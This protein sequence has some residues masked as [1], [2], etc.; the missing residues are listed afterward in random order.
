[1][2]PPPTLSLTASS[3]QPGGAENTP[4]TLTAVATGTIPAGYAIDFPDASGNRLTPPSP[5]PSGSACA[6]PGTSPTATAITYTAYLEQGFQGGVLATAN[7]VTVTWLPPDAPRSI[8]LPS[9]PMADGSGTIKTVK[10][11]VGTL[12]KLTATTDIDV[13]PA[14]Y[15]IVIEDENG[16]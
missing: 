10:V 14:H 11:D 15:Q 1:T 13:G 8:T 12:V 3:N 16:H 2:A 9:D 4:V 5:C 7:S 6:A